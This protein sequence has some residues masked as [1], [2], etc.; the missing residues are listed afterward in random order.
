MFKSPNLSDCDGFIAAFVKPKCQSWGWEKLCSIQSFRDLDCCW[1]LCHLQHIY[2]KSPWVSTYQHPAGWWG[3]GGRERER[4]SERAGDHT[5]GVYGFVR[6]QSHGPQLIARGAGKC[7]STM[8]PGGK[9]NGLV[10]SQLVR[11]LHIYDFFRCG[12]LGSERP[13]KVA[14]WVKGSH[15]GTVDRAQNMC[16]CII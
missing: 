5:G 9:R 8:C 2:R 6:T 14:Q 7:S 13:T 3:E 15:I 11:L 4:A 1:R 10:D 12:N 16:E